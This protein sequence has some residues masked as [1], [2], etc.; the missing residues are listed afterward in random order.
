MLCRETNAV[1]EYIFLYFG[2]SQICAYADS[3]LNSLNLS[4]N[5]C[6]TS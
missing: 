2:E 5:P 3:C 1:C 6:N 4:A